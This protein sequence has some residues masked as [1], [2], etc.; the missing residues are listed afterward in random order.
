ML[1]KFKLIISWI[2][3]AKKIRLCAVLRAKENQAATRWWVQNEHVCISLYGAPQW[4]LHLHSKWL[5]NPKKNTK[6]HVKHFCVYFSGH[7]AECEFSD[8]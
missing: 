2:F 3:E 5:E 4:Q 8:S 7:H 6:N 1:F